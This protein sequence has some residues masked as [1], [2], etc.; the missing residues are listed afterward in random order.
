V[1]GEDEGGN[2]EGGNEGESVP[3]EIISESPGT[4]G[5]VSIVVL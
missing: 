4:G 1:E 5:G 2:A 3:K